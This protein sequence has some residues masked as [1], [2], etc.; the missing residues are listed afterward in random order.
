MTELNFQWL[1]DSVAEVYESDII[2]AFAPMAA[3]MVEW[4]ET[5]G[6]EVTAD[7]GTG[8]GI[9]ARLLAPK[10]GFMVGVDIAPT[11]LKVAYK[12]A[13]ETQQNIA[14]IQ[15]DSHK[16]SLADSSLDLATASFGFNAT[17]PRHIFREIYRVLHSGGRLCFQEWSI[18]HEFDRILND[19]FEIYAVDDEDASD[20]L[21][22]LRDLLS[23]DRPWY[24]FLQTEED[25]YDVLREHGFT[26]IEATECQPVTV[27]LTINEFLRYKLAWTYRSAEVAAMDEYARGDF[28]DY[29]RRQLYEHVNDGKLAY[30]PPLFRVK[31]I[32]P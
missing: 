22:A 25:Y 9:V 12:V 15:G 13:K 16:L 18:L 28:I 2:P 23:D 29:V 32:R 1:F 7:L 4:I 11:M 20:E 14:F 6:D 8:T 30:D 3:N 31:A 19:T 10:V 17:H 5:Q 24:H 21:V 27:Y 26:E